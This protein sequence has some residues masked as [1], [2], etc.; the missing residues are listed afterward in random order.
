M[1]G[2]SERVFT[3][4]A[5]QEAGRVRLPLVLEKLQQADRLA[6]RLFVSP[7]ICYFDGHFPN[8]PILPGVTQIEW[9]FEFA[10]PLIEFP[11]NAA[12]KNVKFMRLI[13]PDSEISLHLDWSPE[14][15][16]LGFRYSDAHGTCSS[17]QIIV[18]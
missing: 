7:E 4:L 11:A 12:M 15:G 6:Y 14:N 13:R 10:R 9:V 3:S 5:V 18:S 17:G 16:R 8:Q 2:D 1:A